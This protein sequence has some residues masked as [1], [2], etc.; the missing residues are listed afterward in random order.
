[1]ARN[2]KTYTTAAG[3]FELAVA[4]PSMKAA[5][6]AW[7]SKMNLFHHG[8][9]KAT[10]DRAV[11]SA[12]MA[13]PG[14]VL[15]RPIGSND[16]FTE[17]AGPP[18]KLAPI[19]PSRRQGQRSGQRPAQRPPAKDAEQ[20]EVDA[21]AARKAER[22]ARD[23]ARAFEQERKRREAE[24]RREEA[25]EAKQRERRERAIAAAAAALAEA[26]R[27][28][29]AKLRTIEQE[30]AALDRRSQAEDDRWMAKKEQLD[31]ALRKARFQQ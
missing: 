1:M 20:P 28:H 15:R 8:L 5:L 7:G 25:A 14:V 9:A 18:R 11:V 22:V 16:P 26:E 29:E 3:F 23:A 10:D 27:D 21:K 4:A 12:T 13:K 24:R 31:A 30:R 19:E 17:H 6:E 2:L